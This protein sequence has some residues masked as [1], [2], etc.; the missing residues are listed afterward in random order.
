MG[1]L[2]SLAT[3]HLDP[4]CYPFWCCT[5]ISN[6]M[7]LSKFNNMHLRKMCFLLNWICVFLGFTTA[8]AYQK[9][10]IQSHTQFSESQHAWISHD[11]TELLFFKGRGF[12]RDKSIDGLYSLPNHLR[13]AEL[14]SFVVKPG[15]C[16]GATSGHW[17]DVKV[18]LDP[19][20][21][22]DNWLVVSNIFY[23]H[24]YLGKV[25]ILTNIFEMGWNHQPDDDET[26]L[27]SEQRLE[28][29]R[30]RTT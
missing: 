27:T 7:N 28:V 24:P 12:P 16:M 2:E 29:E 13:T 21:P 23:V 3:N 4:I 8:W 25:S 10:H 30:M 6:P 22:I 17:Y 11:N 9:G 15:F 20:N 26:F 18:P 5:P 19:L 1:Q 14:L